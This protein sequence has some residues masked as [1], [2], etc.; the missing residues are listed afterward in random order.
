MN[1][2]SLLAGIALSTLLSTAAYAQDLKLGIIGPVTGPNAAFG[3]QLTDG[4]NQAVADLNA[5][6]G[7]LGRKVDANP[8]Q[9]VDVF[10]EELDGRDE[11]LIA[12]RD[13]EA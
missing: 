5:K 7:I 9:R 10:I 3:K 2:R 13:D 6:G 1:R 4:G 12:A 8:G 11:V